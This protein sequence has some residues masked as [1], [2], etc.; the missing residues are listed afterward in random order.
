[1]PLRSLFRISRQPTRVS[2]LLSWGRHAVTKE[3]SGVMES[4]VGLELGRF[5]GFKQN[6]SELHSPA[7]LGSG[8]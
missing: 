8:R 5:V 7:G 3:G 2:K 1:M 6:G 4:N